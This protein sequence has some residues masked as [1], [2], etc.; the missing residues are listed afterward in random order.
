[1]KQQNSL[2]TEINVD[3]LITASGGTN[4]ISFDIERYLFILGT[5]FLFGNPGLTKDEIQFAWERAFIFDNQHKFKCTR[6]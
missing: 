4:Q 6:F 1:M 2:F 5:G 3:E